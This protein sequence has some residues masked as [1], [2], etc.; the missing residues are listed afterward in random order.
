M[1]KQK[2]YVYLSHP[3]E[4]KVPA[5]GKDLVPL[6]LR[7][8]K[9]MDKGDS[10]KT[11]WFGMDNHWGTHVDAPAHFCKNG[12]RISEYPADFWIFSHPQ[13]IDVTVPDHL[14]IQVKDLE[15]KTIHPKTDLLILRT[16]WETLRG[17]LEYGQKNPGV[18]SEVAFWLRT[19]FP[20][21]RLIGFDFISLSSFQNREEGRLA[22]IAFLQE[23][24]SSAPI[25]ILEDMHLGALKNLSN[26]CLEEVIVLP[27]RITPLDSAPCTVLAKVY[28]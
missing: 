5:Y 6:E 10:C 8:D 27:L 26:D 7:S 13:I 18:H 19:H 11:Y 16:G 24:E 2:N 3:L 17:T 21:I 28:V 14:M 15:Q 23:K 12:K 22:H 20:N 9:C 4:E 25:L 1:T